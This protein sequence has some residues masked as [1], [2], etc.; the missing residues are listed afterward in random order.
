MYEIVQSIAQE[1]GEIALS[2]FGRSQEGFVESKGHLDLVTEADRAVE[3]F[4][5]AELAKAFPEDEIFGEEGSSKPGTSGRK[6]VVDP[7]DGTF[8]FVRGGDQWAV[9]IG[10][11]AKHKPTY[12]VTYAPVRKHLLTGGG[13]F[14]A[15]LN[16]Q[17]LKPLPQFASGM[18]LVGVGFHPVI[19]VPDRLRALNIILSDVN[20]DIRTCGAATI[21]LYE[22]ATGLT[23][24]YIGS[25]VSSWDVMAM[26]SILETL[27]VQ[28]NI[29]W[30]TVDLSSKLQFICG[31]PGFLAT[32]PGDVLKPL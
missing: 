8:N 4:I 14:P 19:P 22:V 28:S 9:S 32:L 1:A 13:E 18:G 20:I 5:V 6:W 17:A 15:T 7:I 31:T 11:F 26:I 10:L 16:G 21:S 23:D 27:G 25:G 24:G 3:Q 29:D 12:G 30:A 2:H